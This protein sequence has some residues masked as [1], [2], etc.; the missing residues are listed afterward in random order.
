MFRINSIRPAAICLLVL[1]GT[2]NAEMLETSSGKLAALIEGGAVIVD[3]RTPD[4]WRATGVIP[5]SHLLTF[6]DHRGNYDLDDW[7][8]KFT[9]LAGREDSVAIICAIGNRSRVISHFLSSQLGYQK[10]HN[11]TRGIE[12]WIGSGHPVDNWP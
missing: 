7:L 5:Q 11:V 6:F 4:E 2:V 9:R 3:V 12:H 1:F 10:V 8:S